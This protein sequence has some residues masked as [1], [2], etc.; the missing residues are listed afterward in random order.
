VGVSW[1][2]PLMGFESA[3]E[4]SDINPVAMIHFLLTVK[5]TI[6]CFACR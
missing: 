2:I 1:P 6:R 4:Q 5:N 3:I